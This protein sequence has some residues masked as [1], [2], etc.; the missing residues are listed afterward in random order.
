MTRTYKISLTAREIGIIN[1][2]LDYGYSGIVGKERIEIEKK[3]IKQ[4]VKQL[5]SGSG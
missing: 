1:E 4:F 5:K 3:I 2:L